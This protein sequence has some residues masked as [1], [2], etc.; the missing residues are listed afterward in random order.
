MNH[1]IPSK[2]DV[3]MCWVNLHAVLAARGQPG[4]Q[5][6]MVLAAMTTSDFSR[7]IFDTL[8]GE[9]GELREAVM[10]HGAIAL[11]V[12]L[13]DVDYLIRA[14]FRRDADLK[15]RLY[16]LLGACAAC[17]GDGVLDGATCYICDGTGFEG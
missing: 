5:Q 14:S 4:V 8:V 1:M 15:W 17:F 10:N 3:E 2:D 11:T 13:R 6:Q 7:L 12:C 16:S 9:P